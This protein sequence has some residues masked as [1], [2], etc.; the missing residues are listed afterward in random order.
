MLVLTLKVTMLRLVLARA[1]TMSI[2]AANLRMHTSA[3]HAI[4]MAQT[5]GLHRRRA[6]L[7]QFLAGR[8]ACCGS[9]FC[10]A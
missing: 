3:R 2:I 9:C 4:S 7:P 8:L 5:H 6:G 1:P 10:I